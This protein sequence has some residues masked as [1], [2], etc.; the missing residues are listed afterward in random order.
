MIHEPKNIPR[1]ILNTIEIGWIWIL[2][3]TDVLVAFDVVDELAWLRKE[4]DAIW[5]RLC[6]A[7]IIEGL[8]MLPLMQAWL[9]CLVGYG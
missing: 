1:I 7:A 2:S 5:G 3:L 6:S 8:A 4:D 9:C